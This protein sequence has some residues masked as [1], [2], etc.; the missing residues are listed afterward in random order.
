[1]DIFARDFAGDSFV[2]L[3]TPHLVVL[4]I[5]LV[6]N[7]SLLSLR[8]ASQRARDT[9]RVGLGIVLLVNEIA[10]HV[11]NAAV[12]TWTLQTMLPLHLCSVL[13]WGS[14]FMLLKNNT[15]AYE[16]VYFLGVG[17]GIQAVMT[18][19]LGIY[20][21]PHFRFFQTF[22][23][24]G[25]II[26]AA[27]FMTLVQNQRPYLSSIK[28]VMVGGILYMI[29]VYGINSLVGSNYLFIMHK[30]ETPS[31]IDLLGPWPIYIL[32]LFGIAL[33]EF[34]ILYLPFFVKDRLQPVGSQAGV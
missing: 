14:A 1:M 19:D 22:I 27:M 21:F 20:G 2:M 7:L 6:V 34:T 26:V 4:V 33:L 25:G 17:A 13:V 29:L 11:W 8:N 24:H 16:F 30:P 5:L 9:F 28:R 15:R 32:G 10:W 18:P 23:S 12:G 31:L 3:G